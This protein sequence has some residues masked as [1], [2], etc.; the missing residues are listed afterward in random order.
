MKTSM[1][2]HWGGG[3]GCNQKQNTGNHWL[4]RQNVDV[5][6]LLP[7]FWIEMLPNPNESQWKHLW[8]YPRGGGVPK[9]KGQG[10]TPPCLGQ[11]LQGSDLI[12]YPP[13]YLCIYLSL[14][15]ISSL[16]AYR[17]RSL[18]LSI[19]PV[20]LSFCLS[21]F[22]SLPISQSIHPQG[23]ALFRYLNFWQWNKHAVFFIS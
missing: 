1:A 8:L 11:Q 2:I 17:P 22:W 5:N 13:T 3:G 9:K 12:T 10:V 21:L 23:R 14:Y 7:S 6:S 16:S 19:C 20:H 15:L 4:K 18:Y